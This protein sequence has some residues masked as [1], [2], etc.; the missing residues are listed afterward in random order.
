MSEKKSLLLAI[1]CFN[2]SANVEAIHKSILDHVEFSKFN[3]N[4]EILFIDDGSKDNTVEQFKKVSLEDSQ[5]SYISLSRN[6]GKE[7]AMVAGF[8]YF[9]HDAMVM[10]DADLQHPPALINDMINLWELGYE[11]VYAKRNLRRGESWMK[12]KT[13]KWYYKLL[14]S[15]SQTPVTPDAGDFRLLDK[16]VVLALRSMRESE[17]YTKGLYNVAGFKKA[18][19]DFNAEPRLHGKSK[20]NLK[21]LVNLALEGITSYTTAPL[22]ISTLLGFF[23]SLFAFSYMIYVLTK[24]IIFGSDSSGFPTLVI[25]LLFLGGCILI[26]NGILGEYIARIFMEVKRRPLY[27]IETKHIGTDVRG[28]DDHKD[29]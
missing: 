7:V 10:L 21:S 16:K 26:S 15:V 9:H 12:I 1:P 13:S 4:Y 27:F 29:E 24:T 11:D 8:D 3:L 22:R 14:Q 20:W 18:A 19:I 2:E 25:L 17:R 6:Y 28:K 23:V 5:V